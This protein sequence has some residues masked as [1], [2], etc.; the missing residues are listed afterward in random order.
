MLEL[1]LKGGIGIYQ[2]TD[3]RQSDSPCRSEQ[4][5]QSLGGVMQHGVFCR[6]CRLDGRQYGESEAGH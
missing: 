3:R 1:V 6:E 2:V 4:R 5:W